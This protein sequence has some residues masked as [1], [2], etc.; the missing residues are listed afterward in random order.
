MGITK[1]LWSTSKKETEIAKTKEA[2]KPAGARAMLDHP[3]QGEKIT[4]P[5]YTFRIG[6]IGDIE[7]VAI[8]INNGPWQP[9]RNSSGYWWYDW[10][11]YT[12]GKYQAEA[13][14]QTKDGR[15]FTTGQCNFQVVSGMGEKQ[16]R[17]PKTK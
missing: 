14:A 8:S 17:T 2:V 5:Q 9:C 4:A 3:Q 16:T 10:A 15:V 11:G 1:M 7:L 6:T 12:A 13:K